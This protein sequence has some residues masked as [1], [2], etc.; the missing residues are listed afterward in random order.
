L[1]KYPLD[2]N[3]VSEAIKKAPHANVTQKLEKHHNEMATAV[4]VWHE[5]QYG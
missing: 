5:L 4:I 3:V 2:T 1:I